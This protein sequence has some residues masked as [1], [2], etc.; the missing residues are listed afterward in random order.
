MSTGQTS[1]SLAA[2]A[3]SPAAS[4]ATSM[5]M[6]MPSERMGSDLLRGD[7]DAALGEL[8]LH[9]LRDLG[10]LLG[11]RDPG[12]RQARDLLARR[13]LLALDDRAGMAEAHARHLV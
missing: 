1:V 2:I 9:D 6:K 11:D 13:V 4:S 7:V 8:G 5:P 12:L 3:G 10:D